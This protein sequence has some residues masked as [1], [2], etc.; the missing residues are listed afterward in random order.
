M[1]YGWSTTAA[2]HILC[3][4]TVPLR[5]S[6]NSVKEHYLPVAAWIN[7]KSTLMK[8]SQIRYQADFVMMAGSKSLMT[9]MQQRTKGH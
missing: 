2:M 4:G 9:L 6:F 5:V 1:H 3:W 7:Q 8:R